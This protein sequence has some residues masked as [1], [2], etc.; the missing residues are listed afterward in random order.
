[1]KLLQQTFGTLAIAAV[2]FVGTVAAQADRRVALVI[3]N[4]AY[5]NAPALANP[6]RDATA[7]AAAFEQAGFRVFAAYDLGI[8]QSTGTLR[9]F[10]N[11][12][13]GSDIAVV[14]FAG[15]GVEIVRNYYLIPIDAAP[16]TDR[17]A[18]NQ[19]ISL[20][21][22]VESTSG[23]SHLRL[24]ILDACHENPFAWRSKQTGLGRV[25]PISD[26]TL[27]AYAARPGSTAE[28][29]QAEH[30]PFTSALLN[31]LFVPGLDI[32]LAFG[33]VRGEVLRKTGNRQEPFVYGS[34]GGEHIALIDAP[35]Q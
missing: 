33:R 23:A 27:I 9:Q 5:Q 2:L 19:S 30:S 31:N 16:A 7:M 26:S 4:S 17:D 13:T 11:A 3:G 20:E 22:L 28:D 32:R 24:I 18:E 12:A 8:A 1:M 6:V 35:A 34:L 10:E 14:Y 29:V 21:R 15:Y 25:E